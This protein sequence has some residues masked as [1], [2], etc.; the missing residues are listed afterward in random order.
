VGV[1]PLLLSNATASRRK[2]FEYG[3][4]GVANHALTPRRPRIKRVAPLDQ[5][6]LKLTIRRPI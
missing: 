2:S 3:F 1:L 5:Q 4:R 6:R